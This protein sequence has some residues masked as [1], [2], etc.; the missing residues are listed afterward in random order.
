MKEGIGM[1]RI[2]VLV[3]VVISAGFLF[4]AAP[5]HACCS[6]KAASAAAAEDTAGNAN[7]G[8][9]VCTLKVD[10][11]T[12]G[13]CADS[14]ATAAKAVPGVSSADVDWKAGTAVVHYERELTD[15][16]TIAAAITGAGYRASV[17]AR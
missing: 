8:G 11:M 9:A 10:G 12:C 3:L 16:E 15:P 4:L 2:G 14:V 1:K 7:A 5:A 17:S 13:G 6:D